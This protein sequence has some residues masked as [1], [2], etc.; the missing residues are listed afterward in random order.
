LIYL[1]SRGLFKKGQS[2]CSMDCGLI[3]IKHR[4]SFAKKPHLTHSGLWVDSLKT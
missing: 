3:S 2:S 1:K 4:G